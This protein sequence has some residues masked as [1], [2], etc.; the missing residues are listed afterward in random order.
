MKMLSTGDGSADGFSSVAAA[1]EVSVVE[2]VASGRGGGV[3]LVRSR[4][5]YHLRA[6][7]ADL[8]KSA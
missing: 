5:W 8:R 6:F 3:G 4:S 2:G 7:S 1:E